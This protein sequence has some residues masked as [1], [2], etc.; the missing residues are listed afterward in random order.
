MPETCRESKFGPAPIWTA[1]SGNQKLSAPAIA[2]ERA[3]RLCPIREGEA[4]DSACVVPPFEPRACAI[5][6]LLST[7]R[8][9]TTE[10][11]SWRTGLSRSAVRRSVPIA[12]WVA[13][14]EV[15]GDPLPLPQK[16]RFFCD[17]GH[18]S[19]DFSPI[20]LI[21][22]FIRD[23]SVVSR[24]EFCLDGFGHPTP[25]SRSCFVHGRQSQRLEEELHIGVNI[26]SFLGPASRRF[27]L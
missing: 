15:L 16:C 3:N 21:Q 18:T 10:I 14:D 6:D 8:W 22:G 26:A 25:P 23:G 4:R 1:T 20:S 24:A 2:N 13:A 5:G 12:K 27:A 19:L 9:G 17:R 11:S 7:S